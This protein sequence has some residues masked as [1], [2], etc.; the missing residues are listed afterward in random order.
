MNSDRVRTAHALA[1]RGSP[2]GVFRNADA[3]ASPFSTFVTW[4]KLPSLG[5]PICEVGLIPR[6]PANTKRECVYATFRADP[7]GTECQVRE[8]G[9]VQHPPLF[10]PTAFYALCKNQANS[11]L[12]TRTTSIWR[13][14]QNSKNLESSRGQADRFL[15]LNHER[16]GDLIHRNRAWQSP[17]RTSTTSNSNSVQAFIH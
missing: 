7:A 1:A 15:F 4:G 16:I 8:H 17:R 12:L 3:W 13:L 10:L 6:T 11:L 14:D 5:I 9:N 2:M